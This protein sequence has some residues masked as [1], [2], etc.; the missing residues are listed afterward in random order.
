MY[1]CNKANMYLH[2]SRNQGF[3]EK[4]K[5]KEKELYC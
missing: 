2:V 3:S 1:S 4:I 5:N